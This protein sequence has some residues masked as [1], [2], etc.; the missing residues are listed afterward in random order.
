MPDNTIA[1]AYVQ[2][3]PTTEGIQSQLTEQL[4]S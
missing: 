1:Q 4:G 3:L 2:I